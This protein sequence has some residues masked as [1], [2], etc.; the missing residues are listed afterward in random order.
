MACEVNNKE[1]NS[2]CAELL[3]RLTYFRLF[4]KRP[5]LMMPDTVKEDKGAWK[6]FQILL[7][8]HESYFVHNKSFCYLSCKRKT[9]NQDIKILEFRDCGIV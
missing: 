2:Q 5:D 9:E 6:R 8:V 7:W 4:P 3:V 1:T